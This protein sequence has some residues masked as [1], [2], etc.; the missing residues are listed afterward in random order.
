MKKALK[1]P[2]KTANNLEALQLL[3]FWSLEIIFPLGK[4]PQCLVKTFIKKPKMFPLIL[5]FELNIIL[6]IFTNCRSKIKY[7]GSSK[8]VIYLKGPELYFFCTCNTTYHII[9]DV[10]R[11]HQVNKKYYTIYFF[12][13][14]IAYNFHHGQFTQLQ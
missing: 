6:Y 10:V 3:K 4:A 11:F 14:Q 8:P 1:K 12:I 5:N 7:V 2:I 13:S 9:Q